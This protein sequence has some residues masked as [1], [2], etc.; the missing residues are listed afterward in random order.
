MLV[1]SINLIRFNNRVLYNLLAYIRN[2]IGPKMD[3]FC[4]ADNIA[5][6]I[7]GNLQIELFSFSNF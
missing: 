6:L 4:T 2:G 5:I 1:S 7:N 3:P